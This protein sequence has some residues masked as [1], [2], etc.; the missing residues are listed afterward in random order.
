MR[1]HKELT[2]YMSIAF[3]PIWLAL[4]WISWEKIGPGPLTAEGAG[5]EREGVMERG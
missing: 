4:G 3:S 2:Q 5:G 1:E